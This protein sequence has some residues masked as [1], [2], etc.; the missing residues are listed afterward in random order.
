[1]GFRQISILTLSPP[2]TPSVEKLAGCI[3]DFASYC[4]KLKR[5]R[6]EN[7]NQYYADFKKR[8]FASPIIYTYLN[9]I[10]IVFV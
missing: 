8:F 6:I 4:P 10:R 7:V 1:M 5:I 2:A 9:V 3:V